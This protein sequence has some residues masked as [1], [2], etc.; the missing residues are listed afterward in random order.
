MA[1]SM[2]FQGLHTNFVV[3]AGGAISV[4]TE[5]IYKYS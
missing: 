5:V 3:A 1:I 2:L 4:Q